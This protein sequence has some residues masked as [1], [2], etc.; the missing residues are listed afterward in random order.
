MAKLGIKAAL[1]NLVEVTSTHAVTATYATDEAKKAVVDAV[2]VGLTA[3]SVSE[4]RKLRKNAPATPAD[5]EPAPVAAEAT[6]V[7]AT[8]EVSNG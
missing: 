1:R 8:P 2:S 4:I 7:E 3:L 5:G 6:P